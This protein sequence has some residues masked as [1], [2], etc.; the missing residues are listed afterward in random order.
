MS[1]R[2]R[3]KLERQRRRRAP[4][5]KLWPVLAATAAGVAAAI[6]LLGWAVR[7]HEAHLAR[8]RAREEPRDSAYQADSA[9]RRE[10]V[11]LESW[12]LEP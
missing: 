3:R 9:A 11:P 4:Q 10:I 12:K 6:A 8:L 2:F 5:P 7:A 1:G